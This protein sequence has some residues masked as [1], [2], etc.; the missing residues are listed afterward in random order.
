MRILCLDL[1]TLRPDHLGCYGYHRNTSPNLDWIA[2]Q[3]VRFENYYCSDAPC[4]PSR[5]ALMTGRFGIH[6]G[7]VGH[8][9][10]AADPRLEGRPRGF[11]D[12]SATA[13][14]PALLRRCGLR[15]ASISP[16][17]DRHSAWWFNAGFNEVMDIAAR[18]GEESAEEITPVALD[19]LGRNAKQDNWFLHIN[20]WDPHTPYRAP[21]AFGNPFAADP[22][23][24]WLTDE[25]FQKHL[26]AV[27]PHTAR[28][29]N[30][31]DDR[32]SPDYPRQPGALHTL[33]DLR[34][35]IDGYDCGI[36]HMDDH[37]GRLLAALKR[38]GVLDDLAIIVTADHGENLGELGIYA[39]HATADHATCRIPMIIRWPGMKQGHVDRG[40]HYNLDLLPTLAEQFA[41]PPNRLWDGQ[42]YLPALRTGADC[43]RGQLVLSQCAHVCQRAVRFGDWLYLRTIHDG[44]HLFPQEML[45]NL[46]T[47]PHEQH[48][49]AAARPAV[50]ADA[51]R[52]LLNW[53]DEMMRTMPFGYEADPL[54]TV[55]REGGPEHA[56]G[57][58]PAYCQRLAATGR[59]WAVAELKRRHPDE[60]ARG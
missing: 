23:P 60:F 34:R 32:E 59:G 11:R 18:K 8:G 53:H 43:G 48:D 49:L 52:R 10:T 36:R 24:A 22:L 37:I 6:S 44:Y 55:I 2:S 38:Q 41:T 25:V 7:V 20:Y 16:F 21:A 42:S 13:N 58:L 57:R 39:E 30:M 54:W 26:Q 9:G 45:F 56:R 40:L 29:V 47:D 3:G 12:S 33:A 28:E 14:L 1:D 51:A 50:C 35:L 31:Y 27:G 15:T 4:L 19:W 17:A 46:A 5:A